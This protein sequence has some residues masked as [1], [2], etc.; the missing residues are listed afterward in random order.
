MLR[1]VGG[2]VFVLQGQ[3]FHKIEGSCD[4]G[5]TSSIH[6]PRQRF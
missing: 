3:A 5:T 2:D 1:V 4:S 6:T